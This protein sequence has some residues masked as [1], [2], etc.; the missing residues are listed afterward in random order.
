MLAQDGGNPP[1]TATATVLV[2]VL[3]NLFQPKFE[4]QRIDR[5]ILE[6]QALGVA[7]ANCNATDADTK[8]PHNEVRYEIRGSEKA[9]QF[10]LINEM[11]GEVYIKRPLS[12]DTPETT[13]YTIVVRA[14]DLGSPQQESENSCTVT[15]RVQRN[16]NCP[17]FQGEPYRASI[18]QTQ[19]V[20]SE[21]LRIQATDSDPRV[22]KMFL[23]SVE[24]R[25]VDKLLVTV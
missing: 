14:N 23:N 3:R 5:D 19:A 13:S 11:T 16:R 8:A 12:E 6:T 17:T 25:T 21:V 7:I 24:L 9:T 22:G 20:N 15:V 10:F 18:D 2:T 1:R 4:P